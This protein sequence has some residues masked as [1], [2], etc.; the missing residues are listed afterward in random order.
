MDVH[1]HT[2]MNNIH[3]HT[4]EMC[5][6]QL[7][8]LMVGLFRL[9]PDFRIQ[10]AVRMALRCILSVNSHLSLD[11]NVNLVPPMLHEGNVPYVS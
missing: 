1:T 2:H 4:C 11:L 7:P 6:L 9:Q 8:P 10:M 3:K 5:S